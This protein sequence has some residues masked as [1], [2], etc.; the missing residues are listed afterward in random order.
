MNDEHTQDDLISHQ[1]LSVSEDVARDGY[2]A[3]MN[4]GSQI[5]SGHKSR[6]KDN[7]II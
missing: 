4:G 2:E 5:I 7:D 3:L 1:D 6:I